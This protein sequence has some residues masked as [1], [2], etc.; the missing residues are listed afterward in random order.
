MSKNSPSLM[1]PLA[2]VLTLTAFMGLAL[3]NIGQ[4]SHSESPYA[5]NAAIEQT[6]QNR[7]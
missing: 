5:N 7:G 3:M 2:I 6:D 1:A 4:T